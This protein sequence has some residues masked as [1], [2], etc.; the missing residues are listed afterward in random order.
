MVNENNLQKGTF[1]KIDEDLYK[2]N[3]NEVPFIDENSKKLIPLIRDVVE[4]GK[5]V[6]LENYNSGKSSYSIDGENVPIAE[7]VTA[8]T[9]LLDLFPIHQKTIKKNIVTIHS[10]TRSCRLKKNSSHL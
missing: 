3:G 4:Q 1:E 8:I 7:V 2:I 6:V 5:D 9:N 10:E